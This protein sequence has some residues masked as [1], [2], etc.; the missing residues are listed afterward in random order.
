MVPAHNLF[1]CSDKSRGKFG[2]CIVTT[3][4]LWFPVMVYII[5]VFLTALLCSSLLGSTTLFSFHLPDVELW[6][7]RLIFLFFATFQ[8]HPGKNVGMGR[9]YTIFSLIDGLVKFEKYGPDRKKVKFPSLWMKKWM[10]QILNRTI[11][12]AVQPLHV[13]PTLCN[14]NCSCRSNHEW[15]ISVSSIGLWKRLAFFSQ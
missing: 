13:G 11:C 1:K 10:T 12:L 2:R 8:F 7:M 6:C 9:D 14:A 3:T 5:F 4:R 15:E